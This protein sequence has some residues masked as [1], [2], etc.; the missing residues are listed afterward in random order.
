MLMAGGS[1]TKFLVHKHFIEVE[2]G[3]VRCVMKSGGKFRL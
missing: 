3:V 2:M 1:H